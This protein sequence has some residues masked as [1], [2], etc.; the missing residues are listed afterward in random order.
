MVEEMITD[1]ERAFLNELERHENKWVAL[2]RDGENERIV[3]SADDAV[4]A[5]NAA[6]NNGVNEPIL[7]WVGSFDRG[8]IPFND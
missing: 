8:Y 4:A 3:A 2:V 5:K 1:S 7:Y 6:R